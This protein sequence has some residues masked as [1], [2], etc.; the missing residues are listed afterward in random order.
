MQV[1]SLLSRH[2]HDRP[3]MDESCA[4]CGHEHEHAPVGLWQTLIGVV[5]VVTEK[6]G[7]LH[8]VL[9]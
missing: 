4:T 1:T 9:R 3:G 6:R 5:F 7:D 2:E 8:T